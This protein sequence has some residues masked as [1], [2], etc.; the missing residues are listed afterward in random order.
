MHPSIIY[1]VLKCSTAFCG[2]ERSVDLSIR[3]VHNRSRWPMSTHQWSSGGATPLV[4]PFEYPK[5]NVIEFSLVQP[6]IVAIPITDHSIMRAFHEK[7][8]FPEKCAVNALIH[9]WQVRFNLGEDFNYILAAK[10]HDEGRNPRLG[11][12]GQPPDMALAHMSIKVPRQHTSIDG[13]LSRIQ[14]WE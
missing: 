8:V 2:H 10:V 14:L 12:R 5:T 11:G 13:R 6:T 1:A 3:I 9:G 7:W 4:E